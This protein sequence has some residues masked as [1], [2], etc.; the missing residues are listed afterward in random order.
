VEGND[1]ELMLR[2]ADT[3]ENDSDT[4][5]IRTIYKGYISLVE[6]AVDGNS[7]NVTVHLLGYYMLL[8]LD[9]L[10]DDSQTTL[11]SAT[12]GLTTVSGNLFAED[13][14]VV[15]RAIID[16]L[17]RSTATDRPDVGPSG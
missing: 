6:R 1:V 11:Y 7:E 9:V 15:A 12:G 13:T 5:G 16:R 4:F 3:V 10:K 8:A 17:T 14:G 2:D